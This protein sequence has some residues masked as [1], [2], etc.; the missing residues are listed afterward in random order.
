MASK[1][2]SDLKKDH[3]K[4][5]DLF[6]EIE[7]SGDKAAKKKEKLFQTLKQELTAHAE[8]EEQA[9]YPEI[10]K[11]EKM[12]DM[13]LE[14]YEEHHIVKILLEE[15]TELPADDE[16]WTAKLTVLK[17]VI[18]HHVEEEEEEM[19][20]KAEKALDKDTQADIAGRI[21]E[22]KASVLKSGKISLA[23]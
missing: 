12:K 17:E 11:N 8:A 16:Q 15:L 6:K 2:F 9:L 3:R 10:K 22:I 23:A 7:K 19:F 1:L 21:E 18:E 13:S 14:A 20:K 5:E 4:V